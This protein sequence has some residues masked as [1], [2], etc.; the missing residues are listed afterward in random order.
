MSSRNLENSNLGEEKTDIHTKEQ[1]CWC[2][3][4]HFF[5]TR[6]LLSGRAKFTLNSTS[7]KKHGIQSPTAQLSS[8][9]LWDS[10]ERLHHVLGLQL[11]MFTRFTL[12]AAMQYARQNNITHIIHINTYHMSHI[13]YITCVVLWPVLFSFFFFVL[14]PASNDNKQLF[15]YWLSHVIQ[16]LPRYLWAPDQPELLTRWITTTRSLQ[17]TSWWW[18]PVGSG[19]FFFASGHRTNAVWNGS[20]ML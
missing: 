7:W 6:S 3:C 16:D 13:P 11:D 1:V 4:T 17:E 20:K 10:E 14:T 19:C 8:A 18:N 9:L 15:L 5:L 12:C 2:V